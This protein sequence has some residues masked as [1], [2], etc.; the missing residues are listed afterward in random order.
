MAGGLHSFI[1]G[2][3]AGNVLRHVISIDQIICFVV[4]GW[5]SMLVETSG[6]ISKSV[7]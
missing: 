5:V 6:D 3:F 2:T 4:R 7:E 1:A